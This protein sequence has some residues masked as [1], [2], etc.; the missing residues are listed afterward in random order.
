MWVL[1]KKPLAGQALADV[2]WQVLAL[3]AKDLDPLIL[4]KVLA[5][6]RAGD[7]GLST[8]GARASLVTLSGHLTATL[9]G[10]GRFVGLLPSSVAR[11]S[12]SRAGLRIL[13]MDLPAPRVATAIITIKNRTLSPLAELFIDSAREITTAITGPTK[14]RKSFRN[15]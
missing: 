12:A 6:R 13:A 2:A 11:F 10:T 5:D 8:D 4:G 9:I 15:I 1:G 3:D 14:R 7:V